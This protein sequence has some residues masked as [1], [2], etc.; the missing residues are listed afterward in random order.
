MNIGWLR[1]VDVSFPGFGGIAE[2][3]LCPYSQRPL[4]LLRDA[5]QLEEV[6]IHMYH[7]IMAWHRTT[8]LALSCD[9]HEA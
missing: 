3:V 1:L 7:V 9:I 4:I 6:F 8:R 2:G 5:F